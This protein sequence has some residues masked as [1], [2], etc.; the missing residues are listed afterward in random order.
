MVKW[1]NLYLVVSERDNLVVSA[2]NYFHYEGEKNK[3]GVDFRRVSF[4]MHLKNPIAAFY[5]VHR[6]SARCQ[7][8]ACSYSEVNRPLEVPV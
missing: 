5:S 6:K 1:G 2:V 7:Y 3:R 8:I 4:V